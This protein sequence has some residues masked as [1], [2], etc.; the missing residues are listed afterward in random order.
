MRKSWVAAVLPATPVPGTVH[1]R[2]LK[3]AD[4]PALGQLMWAAFHRSADDAD[5]GAPEDAAADARKALYGHWG[6]VIWEGSLVAEMGSAMVAAVIV[7][8]DD[9]HDDVPL[10]AFAMT[11]PACQG[12][13]IGQ[14]LLEESI[15]RLDT[16][17]IKELHLTVTRSNPAVALYQRLGF[18]VVPPAEH[19]ARPGS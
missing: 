17:G 14:L 8:R 7:V 11:E 9:A 13:G 5:Y 19:H 16:A 6:P 10:L 3:K 15:H 18:V 2:P 1:V 4:E 12:R